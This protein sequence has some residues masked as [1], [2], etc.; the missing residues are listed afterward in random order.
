MI[1][2]DRSMCMIPHKGI[3]SHLS[4]LFLIRLFSGA[5]VGDKEETYLYCIYCKVKNRIQWRKQVIQS[6][7]DVHGCGIFPNGTRISLCMTLSFILRYVLSFFFFFSHASGHGY[8][9]FFF[10]IAHILF[11]I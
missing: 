10:C 7:Q 4:S 8:F 2:S 6:D 3:G 1:L 5:Q 11:A 9:L